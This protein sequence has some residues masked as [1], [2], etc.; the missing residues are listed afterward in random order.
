MQNIFFLNKVNSSLA[1]QSIK[2]KKKSEIK[3]IFFKS[4]KII[5]NKI[6]F[7]FYLNIFIYAS[8]EY[9]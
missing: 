1:N 7:F 2:K 4:K 9:F 6:Y 8:K 3:R 5:K